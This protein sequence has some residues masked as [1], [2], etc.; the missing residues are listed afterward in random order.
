M[1]KEDNNRNS[2]GRW[3]CPVPM[4]YVSGSQPQFLILPAFPTVGL[5]AQESAFLTGSQR[6]LLPG[7]GQPT[8]PSASTAANEEMEAQR[9]DTGPMATEP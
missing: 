6:L 8:S 9:S 4:A 7:E 2:L 5:G 3:L 1:D